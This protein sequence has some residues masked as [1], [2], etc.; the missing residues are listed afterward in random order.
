MKIKFKKLH[1][2]A[3]L[4]KHSKPGDAGLD[5]TAVSIERRV[6]QQ[7]HDYGLAVEIPD[8]Y[9]GLIFPRSSVVN[10]D[11]R[12]ANCVG[13]IDAGYRGNISAIFDMSTS[14]KRCYQVGERSAQMVIVPH[15]TVESEWAEY[16]SETERGAGGYG[17]TGK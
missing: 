5:L 3:K 16:L 6:D 8:G 15:V 12:L 4:P 1:Q 2:D 14:G 17:H 7:K 10:Q 13:V 11:E 9:V